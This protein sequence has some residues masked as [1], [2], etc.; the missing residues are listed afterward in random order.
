MFQKTGNANGTIAEAGVLGVAAWRTGPLQQGASPDDRRTR[1]QAA[2]SG[3]RES[4]RGAATGD[5]YLKSMA[6]RL[7]RIPFPL[8]ASA[9]RY[10]PDPVPSRY[11]VDTAANIGSPGHL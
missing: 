6:V 2:Q 9:R 3:A 1:R 8:S 5:G 10:E 7:P 11:A 4:G